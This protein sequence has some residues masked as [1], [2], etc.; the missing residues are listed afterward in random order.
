MSRPI[1]PAL[2]PHL[3][4]AAAE[5]TREDD[6]ASPPPPPPTTT[7]NRVNEAE[8]EEEEE[9]YGP[10]LP[11]ELQ[12]ARQAPSRNV[13][14]PT[15][16]TKPTTTIANTAGGYGSSDDDDD[17]IG[18]MP[19]PAEAAAVMAEIEQQQRIAE[20]E[21]RASGRATDAAAA[22]KEE[23]ANKLTRGEWMLVPPTAQ[24]S[25]DPLQKRPT[26]FRQVE[27]RGYR[28]PREEQEQFLWTE[29]PAEREQRIAREQKEKAQGRQ[30]TRHRPVASEQQQQPALHSAVPASRGPSLMEQHMAKLKEQKKD[31]TKTKRPSMHGAE[32]A[33]EDDGRFDRERDMAVQRVDVKRQRTMLQ[34]GNLLSDRFSRGK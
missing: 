17:D 20:I 9:S 11:P 28:G 22:D 10:S 25:T 16:P 7:S 29:S 1:G 24:L 5:Q 33:D 15:M 12:A 32:A 19:L 2:P 27:G 26:G 30:P 23:D 3:A 4:K 8:K 31:K 21:A 13:V 6:D 18:P 34:K 14:G